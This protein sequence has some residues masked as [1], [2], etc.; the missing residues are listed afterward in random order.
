MSV[1]NKSSLPLCFSPSVFFFLE[2]HVLLITRDEVCQV[3]WRE[4]T[5][6]NLPSPPLKLLPSPP[7]RHQTHP[8]CHTRTPRY[9]G[10][11][12]CAYYYHHLLTKPRHAQRNSQ[13]SPS[14]GALRVIARGHMACM[15]AWKHVNREGKL[16]N[17]CGGVKK[18]TSKTWIC[19]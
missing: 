4:A 18:M 16:L 10:K 19:F 2:W 5:P 6:P 8:I 7:F 9:N 17:L 15:A 14:P 12:N 3:F 11:F 13:R 1:G